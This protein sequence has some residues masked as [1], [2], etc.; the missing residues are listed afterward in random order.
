MSILIK[1]MEMPSG[2]LSC[3]FCN[4]FTDEP[5]CRRLMRKTPKVTRLEDCPLVPVQP[6]GKLIDADSLWAQMGELYDKRNE[7]ACM[8]GDRAVCVTWH[9]AVVLMKAA[10]TVIE[11][12]EG[13]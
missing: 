4:P 10:P 3:D 8:T 9:D 7:E 11:A 6:H 13:E 2:C 12:E 5:Y 1:G